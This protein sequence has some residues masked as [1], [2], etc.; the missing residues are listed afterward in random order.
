MI[1]TTA[2][3]FNFNEYASSISPSRV[4]SL[5]PL[6]VTAR[7]TEEG[8]YSSRS[9]APEAWLLSSASPLTS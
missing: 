8:T 3:I 4:P 2:A 6:S 1:F 5:E 7:R 9:M